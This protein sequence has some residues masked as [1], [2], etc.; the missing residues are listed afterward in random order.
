[1]RKMT[2]RD[3]VVG[4]SALA[5]ASIISARAYGA[6]EIPF[7]Q[8]TNRPSFRT[9]PQACDTHFHVYD[10]KFPAAANAS[11]IPPD[12]SVADYL[13]L[14][15]RLGFER[16][17]IVQPSTYGT[18]NSCLLNALNQLGPNAR[19]IAVVDT[20]VTTDELKRLASL[21]VKGIRF[22]F[23]RAGATTLDMVEPL[24][25]RIADMGWHIQV[26]IK[27][28]DLASQAALFSRLPVPVVFDHLGRIPHPH[29][30]DHPAFKIVADL[31]QKGKAFTKVSSLY[32]D[33]KDGPPNYRDVG[34]VA[35]AYI[36]AAPDRVLWGSD[37]PH[38]SPGKHGKPDDALLM[39]LAAAW[40]GNEVNRQKIFVENPAKLYGF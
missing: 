32:Q 27:G 33:S 22:N 28:D 14:R 19:G 36:E 12:A 25:A 10:S 16:S 20:S 39:D 37:W 40:A 31:L 3:V 24:A 6:E 29:G 13:R 8:G 1:M 23:G 15:D 26:H 21:G 30:R 34:A 9:P 5:A 35:T 2:R 11:L 18:D 17:V 38:P 4:T 7:T